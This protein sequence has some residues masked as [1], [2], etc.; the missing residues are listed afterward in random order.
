M[1]P[2][3]PDSQN[4]NKKAPV[5]SGSK[6]KGH[7]ASTAANKKKRPVINRRQS[8]HSSTDSAAK[9]E[10]ENTN[11][12]S[13]ERTPP[14]FSEDPRRKGKAPSRFQE[15]FS[16]EHLAAPPGKRPSP[17]KPSRKGKEVLNHSGLA[18]SSIRENAEPGSSSNLRSIE[19][20]QTIIRAEDLTE[21]ELEALELQ[22]AILEQIN[23]QNNSNTRST[24]SSQRSEDL[25]VPQKSIASALANESSRQNLG[26][27]RMLPHD[28]KSDPK[29]ALASAKATGQLELND[30]VTTPPQVTSTKG[31]D[32]G[33]GRDPDELRQAELFAKRPV[34]PIL[35]T[36]T[37]PVPAADS[38][39][40]SKSQLTL[41]LEKDRARS[42]DKK[43]DCKKE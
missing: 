9:V 35:S 29:V 12:S 15:N 19:N 5:A 30:D 14:T 10:A 21:E 38:L 27:I 13:A 18:N 8:S 2:P 42:T 33:K 41:L 17:R 34:P 3:S 39:A 28:V 36:A 37:T 23:S 22:H 7:I 31:R 24:T 4:T 6:K 1:Q 16:L 32:K 25:R 40:R 26:A 20:Q 11:Q 43:R